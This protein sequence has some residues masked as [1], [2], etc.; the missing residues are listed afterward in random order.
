VGYEWFKRIIEILLLPPLL[1]VISPLLTGIAL[2]ILISD[3]RPILYRGARIGRN[4]VIFVQLKFRTMISATERDGRV[5]SDE[6]RITRWGRLLRSTSLD[7]LPQLWN[8]LRGDMSLIGPRPLPVSYLPRYSDDQRRRHLV[9][10]G[11]TGLA[12]VRG[13]NGLSWPARFDAD[14][15]YV[16]NASIRLDATIIWRSIL[17]VL[18]ARGISAP[19]HAT[20]PEFLGTMPHVPAAPVLSARGAD[21]APQ[22]VYLSAP[23]VGAAERDFLM[24]AIDSNWVAPVGPDLDAFEATLAA[25]AHRSY[26]VG[27]SSGTAGLHLCLHAH[28]IGR[29]DRVAMS[30]FTFAATANAVAYTGAEPIF[31]DSEAGSWNIDVDLLDELLTSERHRG[32]PVRAV[33]AVDLY[34]QCCD[35]PR[36]V[37]VCARNDALLI[38]DAAESLG[39]EAHG[40]P[41]G[42]AGAAAVF[43]FNGNKIITTSGG[44]MIVTD[45][46]ALAKRLRFLATQAREPVTHYEHLEVGFNYR[47]SNL[48]AAFGRGQIATLPDRIARR[49][50]INDRYR[51]LLGD[52]EL[53]FAPV[54]AWSRPNHWLSCVVLGDSHPTPAEVCAALEAE[55]IEARPL[56]KPMHRQ[57]AFADATAR[58]TG[59]SDTLFASGLCLPSGSSMS[60]G[61]QERVAEHL[62]RILRPTSRPASRM[63]TPVP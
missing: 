9:R 23:D 16:D 13:R 40:A 60:V 28:G 25:Q 21:V 1:V 49:T 51:D 30:S 44:G 58:V 11:L 29:G 54:P 26:A 61:E 32:Q 56:W 8:V 20:A 41:A 6:D 12:Q 47:L 31:V 19:G 42:S 39:A 14:V 59:V 2:F 5:L 34:G 50:A 45:D 33:L 38:S 63:P 46:A 37:E 27:V 22:R 36:L 17:T 18:S 10:P 62:H 52:L 35:Y 4:D 55:N 24:A 15:E 3:G 7:E 53:G 57:P 48:L 43:S